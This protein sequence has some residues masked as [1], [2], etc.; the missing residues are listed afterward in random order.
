MREGI[1]GVDLDVGQVTVYLFGQGRLDLTNNHIRYEGAVGETGSTLNGNSYIDEEFA[2]DQEVSATLLV[3][4]PTNHSVFLWARIQHPN[5]NALLNA[6][7]FQYRG[8]G[9]VAVGCIVA[10][11]F[12]SLLASQSIV[13]LAN[14]DQIGYRVR[15]TSLTFAYKA[16]ANPWT[17]LPPVIDAQVTGA[18]YVGMELDGYQPNTQITEFGGGAPIVAYT[19]WSGNP[20]RTLAGSEATTRTAANARA[21]STARAA[22]N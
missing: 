1:R 21:L 12:C 14:G 20:W 5:D 8:D 17:E 10:N 18:G 19:Y 13:P 2:A 11:Q 4:P 15:G 22:R 7:Y 6:Y 16:G 9:Y 3:V